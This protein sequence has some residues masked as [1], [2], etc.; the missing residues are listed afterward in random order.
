MVGQG[1]GTGMISGNRTTNFLARSAIIMSIFMAFVV[2]TADGGFTPCASAATTICNVADNHVF[3][4]GVTINDDSGALATDDF[5]VE[6][7]TKEN[8]IDTDASGNT[9]AFGKDASGINRDVEFA[10][11]VEIDGTLYYATSNG[12]IVHT[13]DFAATDLDGIVGSNVP[14][15][16]TFT[17]LV[18]TTIN[19]TIGSITPASGAFTSLTTTTDLAIT[20]GG[21]GASTAADA[22]TNLGLGALAELA[23]VNND[24][25]SGTDL[26]VGN[27]GTGAS[28]AAA[29]RTALDVD[30][31]GTDNSTDI[32]LAGTPDY[33][34]ISGQI[35]TRNAIDLTADVSGDLPVAEGG[36]GVSSLTDHGVMIGSGTGGVSVTAVGTAD[37]VLTSNGAGLD[38]TFQD[39]GGSGVDIQTFTASGT[40]TKPAGITTVKVIMYGAGGGG[41]GGARG[42][43][44]ANRTGGGGGGGGAYMEK[45]FPASIFTG[46]QTVTIGV[47]GAGGIAA[48][49]DSTS[50]GDGGVGGSTLFSTVSIMRL[51][52]A[53]FGEGGSSSDGGAGS[54]A[55]GHS[56]NSS[57]TGVVNG[58]AGGRSDNGA[59]TLFDGQSSAG[60]SGGG[61]GGSMDTSNTNRSSGEG[62][63][64]FNVD[65]ASDS[66][67]IRG[68]GAARGGV[69]GGGDGADATIPY[70]GGGGGAGNTGGTGGDAG[71]GYSVG[72]GGGGGGASNNGANSGAGGDG[73]D[74]F[75]IVLSW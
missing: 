65:D 75:V 27:G 55:Y 6:T 28:N 44:G 63:I 24:Q 66:E 31:A 56:S 23:T 70:S 34:T 29:A 7:D 64:P 51:F 14:A 22:R 1:S 5:R 58:G 4:A 45:V 42:A 11:T 12:T 41:G 61:S 71:D 53:E 74:G 62:G 54:G 33:I 35:I 39:A 67:W 36:T 16:G 48:T 32:T 40:W 26:S 46:N 25:W 20:Q 21:T 37:Q 13:G 8:A 72:G 43:S 17:T 10:G 73:G 30:Q 19:G 18:G 2:F 3:D 49:S 50:G 57:M 59:G 47:G 69:G 38:P 60:S 9:V 15:A 52:G 68:G